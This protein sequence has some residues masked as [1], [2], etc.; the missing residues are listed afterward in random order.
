MTV[1]KSSIPVNANVILNN[2]QLEQV[3]KFKLP[4]HTLTS[5]G[6]CE[7]EIKARIAMAKSAFNCHKKS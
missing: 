4:G 5:N 1:T 6:R 7:E 2:Q 3:I